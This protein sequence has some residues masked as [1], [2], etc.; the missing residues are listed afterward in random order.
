MLCSSAVCLPFCAHLLRQASFFY[1]DQGSC[2]L[3][4]PDQPLNRSGHVMGKAAFLP[5]VCACIPGETSSDNRPPPQLQTQLMPHRCSWK[6]TAGTLSTSAMCAW[7]TTKSTVPMAT[8]R[9]VLFVSFDHASRIGQHLSLH[10]VQFWNSQAC[11]TCSKL[12][13]SWSAQHRLDLLSFIFCPV[14]SPWM[15]CR[16]LSSRWRSWQPWQSWATWW[17]PGSHLSYII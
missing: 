7:P 8:I 3:Q 15:L 9:C 10:L 2:P 14:P 6:P 5:A 16:A 1:I 11:S 4:L 17:C 13:T 12:L